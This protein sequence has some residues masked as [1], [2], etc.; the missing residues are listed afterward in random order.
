MP[1]FKIK[2]IYPRFEKYV[3][4]C[5]ALAELPA[6]SGTWAFTMP[7][8]L[9]IP[10]LIAA[11]PPEIEWSVQ[12]QN[13]EDVTSTDGSGLV[14]ISFFTP[15][16]RSAYEL[17]DRFMK[18][19]RTVVMGGMHPSMAP[20]DAARHCHSVCVGEADTLWPEI[21]GDFEA[22]RL[23]KVY[24]AKAPPSPGE[25]LSPRR[26]IFI[27]S[28]YNFNAS[29][30]NISRGCPNSCSW[31]NIPVYQGRG[32]RLR[33]I[34]SVV[35]ELKNLPRGRIFLGDDVLS[36][37]RPDIHDYMLGFCERVEGLK[38]TL[39][40]SGSPAMNRSPAFL[41]ALARAGFR[42]IFVVFSSDAMSRLFYEGDTKALSICRD[43]V[44]AIEDRGMVF[45]ASFG[46][47]FDFAGE[48]QFDMILEFCR[49]A[50]IRLAEFFIATP[51]PGTP[52]WHELKAQGRLIEPVDWG[53]YNGANVVFT[54]KNLSQERL[55]RG[56]LDL[57]KG[58]YKDADARQINSLL[59]G[60]PAN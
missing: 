31:C 17:G 3:A 30:V 2:F 59:S 43:L 46:V 38:T 52:F 56:F 23:R 28:R 42:N 40:I 41:D 33:R 37:D 49:S 25:I 55:R 8:A 54:P 48:E 10:T 39:F 9:G 20:E 53:R 5:P 11:T 19:G 15:Q 7:P 45:F 13:V 36:L 22:G 44:R 16:A 34:E 4:D 29:L 58:F 57:W 24:R 21:L 60:Q 51:F 1:R 12:D 27:D 26:G 32:I 50:R 18:E 47:G 35:E 14:A 6:A